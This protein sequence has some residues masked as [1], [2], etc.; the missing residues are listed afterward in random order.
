VAQSHEYAR[1]RRGRAIEGLDLGPQVG[2]GWFAGAIASNFYL[3]PVGRS[4]S[5]MDM[6][7]KEFDTA[8]ALTPISVTPS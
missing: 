4:Q 5:R 1:L 8:F 6:A 2:D 3:V 7:G